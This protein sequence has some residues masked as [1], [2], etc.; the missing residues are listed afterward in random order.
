[1]IETIVTEH[2]D[3]GWVV[4]PAFCGLYEPFH[5]LTYVPNDC[6]AA[7]PCI[8]DWVVTVGPNK[9]VGAR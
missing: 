9:F 8:G 5:V 3:G 7:P 1:M 2:K 6:W 4:E